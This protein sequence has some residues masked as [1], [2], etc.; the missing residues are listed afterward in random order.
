MMAGGICSLEPVKVQ[1]GYNIALCAL[2]TVH[3]LKCLSYSI[4]DQRKS[5]NS[6]ENFIVSTVDN[7]NDACPLGSL[8]RLPGINVAIKYIGGASTYFFY[9]IEDDEIVSP[10]NLHKCGAKV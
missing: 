5:P 2:N 10:S 3:Q 7:N 4:S 8:P 6:S 1:Y 9:H